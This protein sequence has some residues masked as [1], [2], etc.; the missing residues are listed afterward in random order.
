MCNRFLPLT[1]GGVC[2]VG[3]SRQLP[4]PDTPIIPNNSVVNS[5]TFVGVCLQAYVA[6]PAR[7][8]ASPRKMRL[9]CYPDILHSSLA[10]GCQPRKSSLR[11]L[12]GLTADTLRLG[13]QPLK[14]NSNG[15][16]AR[17]PENGGYF[18][19]CLTH[20]GPRKFP[21]NLEMRNVGIDRGVRG[22]CRG[23]GWGGCLLSKRSKGFFLAGGGVTT[24]H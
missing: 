11:R 15:A 19:P 24:P 13:N 20:I 21:K 22:E 3:A 23:R 12:A 4:H 1:S 8:L 10:T 6:R 16:G 9:R 7:A 14:C 18:E 2:R 17:R 5:T